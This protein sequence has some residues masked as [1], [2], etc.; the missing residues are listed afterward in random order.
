MKS[1]PRVH[2][3][4]AFTTRFDSRWYQDGTGGSEAAGR[5]VTRLER[6]SMAYDRK[7]NRISDILASS[8]GILADSDI[9]PLVAFVMKRPKEYILAHPEYVLSKSEAR[10]WEKV[11]KKRNAGEPVA[12]I[13]G[14]KEFYSLQFK[15]NRHTLIP[16]PETETLVEEI[17]SVRPASMLDVGTGSGAIA[18]SVKIHIPDC[19]VTA[20]DI[21]I[22]TLRTAAGNARAI[23]GKNRIVFLKSDCFER[24]SD[25]RFDVVASNPPYIKTGELD[26][27][28]REVRLF[29][30]AGALDGGKNGLRAYRVLLAQSKHY[31][32]PGGLLILEISPELKDAL[33][34]LASNHGWRVERVVPDLAGNDRVMTLAPA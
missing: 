13:T 12:Y 1:K 14:T 10:R 32:T 16:R 20:I 21:H 18:V 28:Q 25:Q 4:P 29:E 15:V 23:L 31:L 33:G 11:K 19:R 5:R 6:R 34:L 2:S 7:K 27:L 22:K 26:G 9:L 8:R 30:P 17:V 24:L 3:L